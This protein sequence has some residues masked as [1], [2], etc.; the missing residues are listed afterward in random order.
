LRRGDIAQKTRPYLMTRHRH[1]CLASKAL[2]AGSREAFVCD[3]SSMRA[4]VTTVWC[5]G[6]G[7]RCSKSISRAARR[8]AKALS[9]AVFGNHGPGVD[10]LC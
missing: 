7:S 9:C 3:L 5:S 4:S 1:P 6:Q 10:R 8:G 2:T